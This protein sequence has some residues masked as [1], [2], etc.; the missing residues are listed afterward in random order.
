M[1]YIVSRKHGRLRLCF[2]HVTCFVPVIKVH[3]SSRKRV[4]CQRHAKWQFL[5]LFN[6]I[7]TARLIILNLKIRLTPPK[8]RGPKSIHEDIFV[9]GRVRLGSIRNKKSC[10]N[11]NR[12]SFE[13]YSH[14]G[15]LGFYSSYSA[16]KSK[17]AG[18]YSKTIF[19]I[20]SSQLD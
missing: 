20:I 12:R 2:H 11:A 17:I 15:I 5:M 4:Q 19:L 16:S 9:L 8:L 6:N 1:H 7:F 13:S 3:A 10:N 18:M 14:S